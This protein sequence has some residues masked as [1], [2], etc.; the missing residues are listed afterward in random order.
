[1][2]PG[3]NTNS[4]KSVLEHSPSVNVTV[5]EQNERV[6]LAFDKQISWL[7]MDP[8]SAIKMAEMVKEKAVEILRS[9]AVPSV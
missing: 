9:D 6:I 2:S 3:A 8:V 5:G 7:E 1:M 4:L